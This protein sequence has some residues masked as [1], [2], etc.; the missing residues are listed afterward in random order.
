MNKGRIVLSIILK[1]KMIGGECMKKFLKVLIIVIV[2]ISLLGT[3]GYFYLKSRPLPV[4]E[5]GS[6]N[7]N[8]I[9]DGSYTGE[10]KSDPVSVIVKVVVEGNK[11]TSIKIEKHECGT[12]KKAEEITKDIIKAQSLDVDV[13]SS[14]TLS[15]KVILKAVEVALEKGLK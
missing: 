3:A 11:V 14:A 4:I 13:V 7:F 15:S 6:V 5:I 12:G 10:Y 2:S 9:R 8:N 1:L